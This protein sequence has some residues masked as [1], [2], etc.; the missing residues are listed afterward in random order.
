MERFV[1][2]H[3]VPTPYVKANIDTDAIFP[4]RFMKTIKRTG[5]GQHLFQDSRKAALDAGA[6]LPFDM[7]DFKDSQILVAGENFGCGSSREHAPWSLLGYGFRVIIAKSFADIFYS[8]CLKN[9]ILPISLSGDNYAKIEGVAHEAQ[10][11]EVHLDGQLIIMPDGA[12]IPFDIAPSH[13]KAL[14]LGEDDIAAS[15]KLRDQITDFEQ[16]HFNQNPWL[17][18]SDQAI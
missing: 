8:N 14:E 11:I 18:P 5:L 15:L 17:K 16:R 6:P 2:I 12:Q 10:S 4:A 3:S 1:S 13:K 7:E 9:G